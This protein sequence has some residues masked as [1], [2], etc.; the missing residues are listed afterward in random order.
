MKNL[1]SKIKVI[2]RKVQFK[3]WHTLETMVVEPPSLKHE[4]MAEPLSREI[5][6]YR[7]VAVVLLYLP[8]TDQI[9]LNQQFRIGAFVAGDESPWLM[10]CC[11]GVLD[12]GEEPEAAARREAMEE[13]G[14]IIRDLEFIGKAYPSPGSSNEVYFLY[15]GRVDSAEAGH[16]GLEE[17]GEEIKTHLLSAAEALRMLDS[18]LITNGGAVM[19]LNWFGRNHE[20]LRRQWGRR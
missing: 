2:S 1:T 6:L 7:P 11:A 18:G 5:Y 10:E 9:L 3:G 20:R 16:Y 8:E 17:E 15:C 19:C 4:G 13:T 14:S 12:E